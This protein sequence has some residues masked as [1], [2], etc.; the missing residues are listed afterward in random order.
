MDEIEPIP[1]ATV[2]RALVNRNAVLTFGSLACIAGFLANAIPAY[3]VLCVLK[4]PP[5]M[6]M[7]PMIQVGMVF[8]GAVGGVFMVLPLAVVCLVKGRRLRLGWFLGIIGLVLAISPWFLNNGLLNWV[9]AKRGF[10]MEP[11]GIAASGM[12]AEVATPRQSL[13]GA[14]LRLDGWHR[15]PGDASFVIFPA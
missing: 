12:A 13:R 9:I 10:V 3:F 6:S 1:Y 14:F 11:C 4:F 2:V 15:A 7:R 8:L 5:G